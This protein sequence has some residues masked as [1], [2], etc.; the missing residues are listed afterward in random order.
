[1]RRIVFLVGGVLFLFAL[2]APSSHAVSIFGNGSL[3]DFTG[4]LGYTFSDAT[5]A[6]LTVQ[7]TNTSPP[8]NGGFLTAFVF[9]N[10]GDRITGVTFSDPNFNLLGAP[11]FN[12]DVKASP[13]GKFDIG[14]STGSGFPDGGGPFHGI[15]VGATKTFLFAL[16]GT[17]LDTL[18]DLS[19]VSELSVPS[20][21]MCCQFFV[22]GFTGFLN[23][24]SDKVPAQVGVVPE[25]TT[26]LL[27]GSGLGALASAAY[28]RRR[29]REALAEKTYTGQ[30]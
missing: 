6:T 20:G 21:S 12:N 18:T 14:V 17:G 2:F 24:K 11:T 4:N 13:F 28:A 19:F 3:G 5:N 8:A 22:A 30:R 29:R 26:L 15:A 16:A 27:F 25:P 1:M 23:D 7:L 9:N 10:P